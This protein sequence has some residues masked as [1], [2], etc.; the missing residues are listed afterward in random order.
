MFLANVYVY[1]ELSCG[2]MIKVIMVNLN[3]K[4]RLQGIVKVC[5]K[6]APMPLN[7]HSHLFK[8]RTLKNTQSIL[9]DPRHPQ[10]VWFNLFWACAP[11]SIIQALPSPIKYVG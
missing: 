2:S 4:N 6:I 7:D 8:V 1:T 5:G 3:N 10:S 9:A 11:L